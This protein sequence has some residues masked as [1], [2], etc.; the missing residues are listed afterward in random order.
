MRMEENDPAREVLC[1]KPRGNGDGRPKLR[2]CNKLEELL[3]I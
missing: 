2:W 3:N 1:T